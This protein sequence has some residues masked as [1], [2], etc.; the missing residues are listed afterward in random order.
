MSRSLVGSVLLF[1]VAGCGRA[2]SRVPSSD[3]CSMVTAVLLTSMVLGSLGLA[4]ELSEVG[5]RTS[6]AKDDISK[7]TAALE[8]FQ[9]TFRRY[10]PS[11]IKLR[12]DGAYDPDDKLDRESLKWLVG[13]WPAIDRKSV[14]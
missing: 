2:E 4:D 10:P 1:A 3:P 9:R 5:D 8:S 14:V 7:L 6:M 12:E 13:L 11:R